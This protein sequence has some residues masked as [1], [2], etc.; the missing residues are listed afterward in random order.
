VVGHSALSRVQLETFP[1]AR[2]GWDLQ[3]YPVDSTLLVRPLWDC[4][5]LPLGSLLRVALCIVPLR[6]APDDGCSRV[7][8]GEVVDQG[9]DRWTLQ[10]KTV[11]S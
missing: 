7:Q 6:S 10:G 5:G 4:P 2:Y 9:M 11:V 1:G 8:G 3:G